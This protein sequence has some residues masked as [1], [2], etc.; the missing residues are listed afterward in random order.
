MPYTTSKAPTLVAPAKRT[1]TLSHV[2]VCPNGS[3]N[4]PGGGALYVTCAN[5][6]MLFVIAPPQNALTGDSTVLSFGFQGSLGGGS[7]A[8][9]WVKP[10]IAIIEIGGTYSL[11]SSPASGGGCT[12][13]V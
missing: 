6:P 7:G 5:A 12:A 8:C 10:R 9:V 1:S 13:L 11:P 3:L 2:Q 4:P